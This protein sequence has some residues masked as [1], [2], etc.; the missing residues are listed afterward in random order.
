MRLRE[1]IET[2]DLR[3]RLLHGGDEAL[4]RA[5][6]WTYSSDLMDPGRYL[7]GGE[8]VISGLVWRRSARDSETFVSNLSSAGALALV[9]GEAN[10]GCV[11]DDVLEACRRHD[12]V[13][14]AVPEDVSFTAVTEHV[15]GSAT[16]ERGARLEATLGRHRQLLSSLAEGQRLDDLVER[17][18]AEAGLVCRVLTSTGR[19]VVGGPAPLAPADLERV[20]RRFLTAERFPAVTGGQGMPK[21][22]LFP[23]GPALGS[24]LAMWMVVVEGD[25]ADWAPSTADA[26]AELAAITQL[27]RS[28]AEEGRRILAPIADDALRLVVSGATNHPET[29]VRLRQAGIDPDAPLAVV[30]AGF[31]EAQPTEEERA[32][33]HEVTA[34]TAGAMVAQSPD[35]YTVALVPC[36]TDDRADDRAHDRA[37][38]WAD[39][40]ADGLRTAF[41]RLAPGL[42]R[43][44]LAV[45]LSDRATLPGLSG[46]WEEARH[47]QR[48]A[49]LADEPVSIVSGK[50]ITSHVLLLATVPDDIRRLFASRVLGPVLDYDRAH[51][52]GLLST[53]ESF[54]ACSGSWNRTAQM[55]HL[56]VNSVRYRI[57]RV[58]ELTGRDLSRLEDRVDVFL[59][60]R[61][62]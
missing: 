58:E 45:G 47:A 30:V 40:W 6:R 29:V 42:G 56:H 10:F 48:L 17:V 62:L 43:R 54:L 28:R 16:L 41:G 39:G 8:L 51:G 7:A 37:D 50:E 24:R 53:V 18:G 25:L 3:L 19:H 49:A 9:A 21:Y 12:L 60:L 38:G 13:L 2:P 15:I 35:G 23:V 57:G 44:R 61:S 55:L 36:V 31:G 33:V 59:A 46:M 26:L 1:L 34:G 5:V 27:E 20:T 22:S 11:P 14:V 52:T 32:V 4:E